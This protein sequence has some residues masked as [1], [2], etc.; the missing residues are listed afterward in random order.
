MQQ[1]V[2]RRLWHRR[3]GGGTAVVVDQHEERNALVLDEAACV[4]E[5]PRADSDQLG[6]TGADGLVMLP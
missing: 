3:G 6:A 1:T 4:V 5:V 2:P